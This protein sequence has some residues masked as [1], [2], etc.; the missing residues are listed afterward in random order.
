[1]IHDL[2]E[3]VILEIGAARR[4]DDVEGNAPTGDVVE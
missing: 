3:A 2:V 1:V 4:C